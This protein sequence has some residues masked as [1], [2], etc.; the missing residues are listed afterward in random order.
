MVTEYSDYDFVMLV[1]DEVLTEYEERYRKTMDPKIDAWVVTLE[2]F[3]NHAAWG[4]SGAWDRYN[5]TH[6][7]PLVDKTPELAAILLEKGT[8]R[9]GEERVCGRAFGRVHQPGISVAEMLSRWTSREREA[10]SRRFGPA[11]AGCCVRPARTA[12]TLLQI[13]GVG[14]EDVS[15]GEAD[16]DTR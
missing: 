2:K 16:V 10:G 9:G 7:T 11:D 3:R 4:S 5:F 14:T 12:A 8:A 13:P 15:L 1:N 6:V